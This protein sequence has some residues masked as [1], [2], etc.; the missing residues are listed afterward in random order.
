[1]PLID[2]PGSVRAGESQI[3]A[4]RGDI[5]EKLQ[6]L[7]ETPWQPAR[8]PGKKPGRPPFRLGKGRRAGALARINPCGARQDDAAAHLLECADDP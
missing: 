4:V 8:E 1:M 5:V 3:P 2:Q 6:D 7:K